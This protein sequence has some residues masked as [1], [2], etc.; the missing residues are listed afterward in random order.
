[1]QII[2]RLFWA[3]LTLW[4][5]ASSLNAGILIVSRETAFGSPEEE[6]ITS[7]LYLDKDRIRV[8]MGE[9]ETGDVVI[10]RMDQRVFWILNNQNKTYMEITEQDLKKMAGTMNE[11]MQNMQEAMK[12]LPP[13]QR[14]MMEEMMKGNLPAEKTRTTYKKVSSGEKVGEWTTDKYI[15]MNET[16]VV[17]EVWTAQPEAL[18]LKKE[19]FAGLYKMSELFS[20]YFK[21]TDF[22]HPI[23]LEDQAQPGDYSGLPLRIITYSRGMKMHQTEVKEIKRQNFQASLF[24]LPAGYSKQEMEEMNLDEE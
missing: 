9:N 2:S 15:A 18:G 16:D 4:I 24:D 14:A 7:R 12:D 19:D 8:E 5:C 1:M 11:A 13:E 3:L 6:N 22:Y 10:Y 23:I 17:E 21:D 20:Q